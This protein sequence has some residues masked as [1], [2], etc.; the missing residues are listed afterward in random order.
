M[1]GVQS[2]CGHRNIVHQLVTLGSIDAGVNNIPVH[3]VL[4]SALFSLGNEISSVVFETDGERESLRV[5]IKF[6]SST[7]F[8][9]VALAF[10]GSVLAGEGPTASILSASCI[11]IRIEVEFTYFPEILGV[12]GSF[13]RGSDESQTVRAERLGVEVYL[14]FPISTQVSELPFLGEPHC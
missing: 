10:L 4:R 5:E 6:A 1:S 2:V 3:R 9:K 7:S 8:N 13:E 14:H 12:C 11:T